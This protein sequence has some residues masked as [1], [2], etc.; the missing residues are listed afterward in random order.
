V[1]TALALT[2]LLLAGCASVDDAPR[3]DQR[4]TVAFEDTDARDALAMV[5]AAAGATVTV[6][7]VPDHRVSAAFTRVCPSAALQILAWRSGCTV[8]S[9]SWRWHLDLSF[10]VE[11]EQ[12]GARHTLE[13]IASNLAGDCGERVI[14]ATDV[15]PAEPM[16]PSRLAKTV[17][18]S[19]VLDTALAP[20]GLHA[21]RV[22][23]I[24]VLSRADLG[25]GANTAPLEP[26]ADFRA[27]NAPANGWF[28]ML[29]RVTGKHVEH[30]DAPIDLRLHG[31]AEEVQLATAVA[32]RAP[33]PAKR[34]EELPPS[35]TLAS[36]RVVVVP[37]QA[38]YMG[39]QRT[40]A[41]VGGRVVEPG[42]RLSPGVWIGAI[43]WD[44]AEILAG[45]ERLHLSV[46]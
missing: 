32:S 43:T 16:D 37:L 4:V 11:P 35:V 20:F 31:S 44:G 41:V 23:T 42:D 15:D 36:G 3:R 29:E 28:A 38:L 17:D 27:W 22:G 40:L 34:L 2:A 10:R 25:A 1:R 30:G 24:E 7:G 45:D 21:T 19:A 5:G 6:E 33:S 46:R 14:L 39:R 8:T 13:E 9:H 12:P 18:G 26:S